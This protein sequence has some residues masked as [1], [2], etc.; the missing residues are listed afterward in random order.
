MGFLRAHIR[1]Q[2]VR[3]EY[4][5]SVQGNPRANSRSAVKCDLKGRNARKN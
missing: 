5:E 2:R 3:G 1:G 4:S